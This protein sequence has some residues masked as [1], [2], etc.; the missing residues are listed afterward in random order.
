MDNNELLVI[1]DPQKDFTSP[2]GAY[3]RKH[4]VISQIIIARNNIDAL[5]KKNTHKPVVVYSNYFHNQ[6]EEGI[7]FCIPGTVGHEI[8]LNM[9]VAIQLIPKN[10][11]SCFTSDG[12]KNYLEINLVKSMVLCGFLAEYCVQQTAL[13]GLHSGYKISLLQEYIGT[14]DDVQYRK[15]E[16]LLKLEQ[17]GATIIKG[18]YPK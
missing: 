17:M 7:S 18:L 4:A 12:F 15:D 16:M 3:A 14:G 1:I 8:D 6:F 13:D 2:D 5:L 10:Q 11:H 9:D